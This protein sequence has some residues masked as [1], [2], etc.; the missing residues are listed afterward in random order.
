MNLIQVSPDGWG[1]I[2]RET[3]LPFVPW[4]CNYYDPFTG[5]APKLWQMFDP[6]RV[7]EQF[8]H[9]QAVGVN[10]VRVFATLS[11]VL[12]APDQVS[13]A[14][15]DKMVQML[16]IAQAHGIRIIWSGPGLW[17]GAPPWWHAATPEECFVKPDLLAMQQ[18]AWEGMARAM[19]GHPALFAY[20]LYNEPFIPWQG[21]PTMRE[22]WLKWRSVHAPDAPAD[23]PLPAEPLALDWSWD[24]QRF[25]EALADEYLDRMTGTIRDHD[26][27]HLVTIG[28]HQKS[29]P[30]DWYPPDP[31]AAFNPHRLQEMLDYTSIHFYP[32]HLFHPNLYR[33]PFET[34]EGMVETRWQARADARYV[35]A[36]N[37]PVLMEECGWYGGGAVFFV[38]REQP[39][40]TEQQQ[41]AW[42]AG[43]V[44]A[45]QG[46]LCGWLFW[47]Y[48]DTPSSLDP[49]RRSGFYD[50]EGRL[51]D[52][53]RA[54]ARLAPQITAV[55]PKRQPATVQMA[56]PLREL[57][58]MPERIKTFRAEVLSAFRRGEVLDFSPE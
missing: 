1:F 26:D 52:W 36:G 14:G 13:A 34:E 54:F 30:F 24:L 53:G 10:I 45:T 29:V 18:I 46:D 4:G 35:R 47:P 41:T 37:K 57:T 2:E 16:G 50:D 31:Y 51:K 39:P 12:S 15:I 42:C 21:T 38:N 33:D 9:M 48:R 44:E 17:E 56:A 8:A 43:L 7:T 49:S 58:T 5:W 28:L 23:L 22:R 6:A 3:N 20:D 19:R 55:P 27:T 40:L 25:R 11:N 32:H